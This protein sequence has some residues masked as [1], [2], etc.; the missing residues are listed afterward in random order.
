MIDKLKTYY[1]ESTGP[2]LIHI[3]LIFFNV[4]YYLCTVDVSIQSSV[5]HTIRAIAQYSP[6]VAKDIA[7]DLAPLVFLA[8]HGTPNEDGE[9]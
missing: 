3:F 1:Y 6:D 5:A 2:L 4:Y 8:M 7:V 9:Q